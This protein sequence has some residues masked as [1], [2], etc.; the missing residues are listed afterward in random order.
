MAKDKTPSWTIKVNGEV[1]MT[2]EGS[3]DERT[4]DELQQ[5]A[6]TFQDGD[7]VYALPGDSRKFDR[8][9][10]LHQYLLATQMVAFYLPYPQEI[11]ATTKNLTFPEYRAPNGAVF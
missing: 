2:A 3:L 8:D 7:V 10:P 4:L 9:D 5:F 6:D 11:E 1:R